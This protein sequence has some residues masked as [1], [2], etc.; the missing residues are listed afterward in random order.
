MISFQHIGIESANLLSELSV[1]TF[2]EAYK[3]LHSQ[4][5]LEAYCNEHYSMASMESLLNQNNTEV[6]VAFNVSEPAGFYIIKHHRCP[7]E[8]EVKS[9][10]LKQIYV[11]SSFFGSG[12]GIKLFDSAVIQAKNN[13]SEALWLCV[14]DTNY[15]AQ[16]FYNKLGFARVGDGPDLT[17]GDEVLTSS[18][19]IL[20]I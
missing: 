9:T 10:E 11:L 17:V 8:L 20:R 16:S 19:L 4:A 5:N 2:T 14:S 13:R 6:I 1:K 18:I 7:H 15:R 12:L 3:E